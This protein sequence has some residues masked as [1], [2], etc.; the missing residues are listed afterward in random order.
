VDGVEGA[1]ECLV[2]DVAD[3]RAAATKKED[4]GN[5]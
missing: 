1:T 5:I 4:I 3:A 2:K